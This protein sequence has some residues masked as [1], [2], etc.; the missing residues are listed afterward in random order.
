MS[1]STFSRFIAI[2]GV[3]FLLIGCVSVPNF[4]GMFLPYKSAKLEGENIKIEAEDDS[5]EILPGQFEPPFQT[6][7]MSPIIWTSIYSETLPDGSIYD[8]RLADSAN[9]AL[10]YGAKKVR[11]YHPIIEKPLYGVL[12][13]N[14]KPVTAV[15]PAA[16]FYSIQIPEDKIEKVKQGSVQ[17]LYESVDRTYYSISMYAWVLWVS[18]KP[19]E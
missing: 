7:P 4:E 18:D 2:T 6:S 16:N 12:L 14:Q 3:T 1:F 19:F 5:F 15:G 11:L 10:V 17:V 13:L 8:T 9:H